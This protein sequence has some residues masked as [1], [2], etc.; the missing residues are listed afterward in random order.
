MTS[1]TTKQNKSEKENQ[2][3]NYMSKKTSLTSLFKNCLDTLRD[4]ES[5]TGEKALRNLGYHLNLRLIEPKIGTSLDFDNYNG[6]SMPLE[7][8]QKTLSSVK[9]SNWF[10]E[11]DNMNHII[12]YVIFDVLSVHPE[13]SKIF[14]KGTKFDIKHNSTHIKLAKKLLDFNFEEIEEDILGE[15]YEEVIKDI[16]TGKVLGQFFTPPPLKKLIVD[17][18]D[19]QLK[20]DGTIETIFDPAMGTGGFLIT[21]MRHILKQSREKNININWDFVKNTGLGGREA[22]PDTY[23]LAVSNMLISSGRLFNSLESGDSIRNT[24]TNKYDIV[25]TNPPFGIKGLNYDD[26]KDTL[27]DEYLPIKSKNAVSLFL[28]AIIYMLKI[29]GR[30]GVVLP[31]GQDLFAT[32]NDLVMV[33]EFLMKTCDL[34]EVIHIPANVFNNT[35]IKTCV[36]IFTKKRDG[37]EVLTRTNKTVRGKEVTEIKICKEH[38]TNNVVFSSYNFETK[39]K[40]VLVNVPIADIEKNNYSLNCSQYIEKEEVKYGDGIVVKTLGE[41]CEMQGG[42]QLSK[43]NFINGVYPVIGGGQQ[44]SGYHNTFNKPK[45]SILCSSS[46]AYAGFI[47]KYNIEVW[48]SDC[49]SIKSNSDTLNDDY[50]YYYLKS[51]QN[52]IYT[53]QTGAAQPHVYP[54]SIEKIKIPIPPLETQKQIVGYLDSLEEINKTKLQE[55]ELN[56]KLAYECITNATVQNIKP[57]KDA[58]KPIEDTKSPEITTF[59]NKLIG[60]PKKNIKDDEE[61]KPKISLSK[62]KKII[63]DED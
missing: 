47:S 16:M 38:Q 62:I 17:I 28:Q 57:I 5:L 20:P 19:P 60:K 26:I 4:C 18:I 37:K 24:I 58:K 30:C 21:S 48:A 36:F 22:E 51:I 11:G 59:I 39:E 45:N 52:N 1:K 14:P 63:I 8:K 41:V 56:K 43:S 25:V 15:A 2:N 44:P 6:Y 49:F 23:Q 53:N 32:S 42:S 31:D 61:I 35:S 12:K 13:T 46:G 54:K 29:N 34:K 27:R 50:L 7:D 40:T 9:Y 3:V 10:K 33:R 55:I